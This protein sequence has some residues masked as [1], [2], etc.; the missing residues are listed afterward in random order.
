VGIILTGAG[1][2]F[3]II[4]FYYGIKPEIFNLKAFA[5]LSSYLESRYFEVIKNQMIEEIGGVLLLTGLFMIIFSREK[6]ENHDVGMIRLQAFLITAYINTFFLIISILFTFGFGF[7]YM[8]ILNFVLGFIIY[9][10]SFR[11]MIYRVNR[12]QKDG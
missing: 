10:I 4:R 6:N 12:K 7:V 1:I 9:L 2:I 3:L 8:L 5:V 11:I